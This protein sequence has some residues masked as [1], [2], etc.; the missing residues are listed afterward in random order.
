MYCD[1]FI[2][3]DSYYLVVKRDGKDTYSLVEF[4]HS[5]D[6]AIKFVRLYGNSK[7]Y[8]LKIK[9]KEVIH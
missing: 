6:T 7:H 2:K 1:R 4:C 3:N 9:L 8:I 5:F